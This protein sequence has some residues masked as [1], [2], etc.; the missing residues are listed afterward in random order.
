MRRIKIAALYPDAFNLNA[1][2]GNLAVIKRRLELSGYEV[3]VTEV[4]PSHYSNLDELN[5]LVIGSP[6]SSVLDEALSQTKPFR[7]FATELLNSNVPTLAIS[8][9]LHA[10]GTIFG[11][12]G[13]RKN[14][15]ELLNFTT[16]YG[17]K[18]NV[19]IGAK[20]ITDFGEVVGIENHNSTVALG[21]ED[22]RLGLVSFGV[23][24]ATGGAEGYQA[25]NFFGTHLH[26][27][28]LA[29]NEVFADYILARVVK[30]AGGHYEP[31]IGMKGLDS[32]SKEARFHLLKRQSK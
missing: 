15:L 14:S 6:S 26:G 20:I 1:D 18:Q 30:S 9:G 2:T 21:D 11:E 13:K 10:F 28:V 22:E 8:N 4:S 29:L 3:E 23:G 24:N 19:T 27:P 5:F 12:D 17:L 7:S 25:G 16:T 32:L 31:G